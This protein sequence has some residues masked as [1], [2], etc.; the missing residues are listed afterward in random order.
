MKEYLHP[1]LRE[2]RVQKFKHAFCHKAANSRSCVKAEL[3]FEPS[4]LLM[5]G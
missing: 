2:E 3:T 4:L 5:A 1:P